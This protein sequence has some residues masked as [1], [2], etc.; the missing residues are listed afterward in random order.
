MKERSFISR[1]TI[2]LGIAIPGRERPH[3][4]ELSRR[5]LQAA[6]YE[7]ND[8]TCFDGW[9]L[10]SGFDTNLPERE[11]AVTL[12]DAARHLTCLDFQALAAKFC[13]SAQSGHS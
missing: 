9:F 5:D 13:K 6:P 10:D 8:K 3:D 12:S 4:P 1:L 11:K 7:I 2:C